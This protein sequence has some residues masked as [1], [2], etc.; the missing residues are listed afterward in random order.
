MH[1]GA[2][3]LIEPVESAGDGGRLL[4]PGPIDLDPG[5]FVP[6][7]GPQVEAGKDPLAD[8]AVTGGRQGSDPGR[9]RPVGFDPFHLWLLS[10]I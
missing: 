9:G 5:R 8:A 7:V 1:R 2:V 4:Q 3:H 10:F 6:H